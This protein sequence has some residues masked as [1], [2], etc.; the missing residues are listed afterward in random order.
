MYRR[1]CAGALP[2]T[3]YAKLV[4]FA[5]GGGGHGDA[6]FIPLAPAVTA[7]FGC[8]CCIVMRVS[9]YSASETADDIENFFVSQRVRE[10]SSSMALRCGTGV[11]EVVLVLDMFVDDNDCVLITSLLDLVDVGLVRCLQQHLCVT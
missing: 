10:R 5:C 11:S 8:A 7:D 4:T 3:S 1:V 2:D 9:I 6:G